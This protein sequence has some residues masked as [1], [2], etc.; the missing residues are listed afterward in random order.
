MMFASLPFEI[1][2]MIALLDYEVLFLMLLVDKDL[3]YY[4]SQHKDL[5]AKKFLKGIVISFNN[6]TKL[7]KVLPNRER[8]G[9]SIKCSNELY[10]RVH[11]QYG[12]VCAD[13][14]NH[15][16]WEMYKERGAPFHYC[17]YQMEN[18][19]NNLIIK[20][21]KFGK[22]MSEKF[23]YETCTEKYVRYYFPDDFLNTIKNIPHEFMHKKL[24]NESIN[25]GSETYFRKTA[26]VRYCYN[27]KGIF[28]NYDLITKY[29]DGWFKE[30]G[31]CKNGFMHD[32][33]KTFYTG[34]RI[35]KIYNFFEG[36][37]HG[38][39]TYFYKNGTIKWVCNF[40]LGKLNGEYKSYNRF[41]QII[42]ES[43][44]LNGKLHGSVTKNHRHGEKS[45]KEY[46]FG[47]LHGIS[48]V[49][50]NNGQ[51]KSSFKFCEG[52]PNGDHSGWYENGNMRFHISYDWGKFVG[53]HTVWYENGIKE[54]ERV[55]QENDR[56]KVTRWYK[57]GVL[58]ETYRCTRF[59]A[60]IG[61]HKYWYIDGKL[62][63]E[64]IYNDS[65]KRIFYLH[66]DQNGNILCFEY[67]LNKNKHKSPSFVHYN[68]FSVL[69]QINI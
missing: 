31:C 22:L 2:L 55:F 48:Q 42:K 67:F 21:Y 5:I 49:W 68:R 6:V 69:Q 23:Y 30:R 26:H 44:Y 57:N 13:N 43:Q 59:G 33:F 25:D 32:E 15:M 28:N 16:L 66:N 61:T 34:G 62:K 56:T 37:K 11:T 36:Y 3:V 20:K 53:T 19:N 27:N 58:R 40:N 64:K 39:F 17:K 54:N 1:K 52:E 9:I 45:Y 4:V 12:N 29:S 46:S 60:I 47:L 51:L 7:Y 38:S 63:F 41:G 35:K 50:Y 14:F 10:K 18:P 24:R 8:H 65:H